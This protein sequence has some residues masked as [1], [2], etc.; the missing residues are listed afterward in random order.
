MGFWQLEQSFWQLEHRFWKIQKSVQ[1]ETR[2]SV[3]L[4]SE[5]VFRL[6]QNGCSGWARICK[7]SESID[8][9]K[10][11]TRFCLKIDDATM[12]LTVN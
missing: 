3:Q 5:W 1:L 4:E 7:F 11:N 2:I 12:I 10:K 6:L 8:G 9:L